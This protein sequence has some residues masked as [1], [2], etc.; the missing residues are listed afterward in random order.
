[1]DFKIQTIQTDYRIDHS[2]PDIVLLNKKDKSCL[3]IDIAS[4]PFDTRVFSKEKEK[5]K[6]YRDLKHKNRADMELSNGPHHPYSYW[7]AGYNLKGM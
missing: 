6:N 4:C 5:I 3:I 7:C 1:M 2:K